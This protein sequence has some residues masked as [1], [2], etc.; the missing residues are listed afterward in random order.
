MHNQDMQGRRAVVGCNYTGWTNCFGAR[1]CNAVYRIQ[2]RKKIKG[3]Y[4]NS[5]TISGLQS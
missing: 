2:G 4:F 5:Q 1:S 3:R